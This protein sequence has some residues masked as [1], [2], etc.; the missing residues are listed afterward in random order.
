MSIYILQRPTIQHGW[1][2]EILPGE[3]S[4][5]CLWLVF[6]P[7]KS[8][9]LPWKI[10][11]NFTF[12]RQLQFFL[13]LYGTKFSLFQDVCHLVEESTGMAD[14][15]QQLGVLSGVGDKLLF[16][17]L[18][19]PPALFWDLTNRPQNNASD[20]RCI[21][22]IFMCLLF[23]FSLRLWYLK[24]LC[25]LFKSFPCFCHTISEPRHIHLFPT[26]GTSQDTCC[27]SCG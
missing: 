4:S 16:Q 3:C 14:K 10:N 20:K 11:F 1:N 6:E 12:W 13:L 2:S 8:I 21:Q 27:F 15:V 26:L 24:L 7:S 17:V 19:W 23:C 5:C 22:P 18:R 25:R 9:A